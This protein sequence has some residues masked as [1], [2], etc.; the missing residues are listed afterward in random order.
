MT[1][2][3]HRRF[4][5]LLITVALVAAGLA[6]PGAAQAE[7][8]TA[9]LV[10]SLQSELGCPGDWQPDCAATLMAPGAGSTYGLT[11]TVPA[12]SYE[13]KV[14]INGS[15]DESYGSE[16]GGN[17]PLVIQGPAELAFGYDDVSHRISIAPTQLSGPATGADTALA[18]DS[19]R[20]GL[21][22]ERFYFLMADRFANGSGTN[23]TGGLT[24][25]RL[26][27]GFDPTDKGF[28]HGGDLRGVL[29]RLDYIKGLGTTAIWLTPS[30]KNRPVQGTGADASAGYHGYWITDFTQIDP[31]LGTNA[32]MRALIAAAHAK[33]M[34]VFFDIITNHTADVIDYA[35]HQ[36]TYVSKETTPYRDASGAPF[37][38]AAY[39][40]GDSFPPVDAATSFPYTPVFRS[41]A[42]AT[43]KVP[44]WLNDPT[45]YH[46][47]G[48]STFAGESSTY[49]DFVGLDDLWTERP[50]VVKGM[51]E[52]YKTWVDFGIDGF[53]IDTVKHVNL[54]FWQR[55]LPQ[56]QAEAARVSK[57][58]FFM[59]GEIYDGNPAYVSQFTTAGKLAAALDFP[60]QGAAA[61]FAAGKPTTG[62]RDV[63]AG[64]D[65][66][67]DADSNAYSSPT[68]L[69]NHDMGRLAMMLSKGGSSGTDLMARVKLAN[70]LMFLTRG[71]P[72]V[73]YGDEQGFIGAGGDKDARQDMFGTQVAQYAAET[74]VG[75]ATMGTASHFGTTGELYRSIQRLE[76]LRA[77]YPALADGAQVHRLASAS[78]GIFAVSRIDRSDQREYLV[79]LNNSSSSQSASLATFSPGHTFESIYGGAGS[80]VAGRDGRV[81]LTVPA[82][83]AVVLRADRPM[84]ARTSAP[85]VYVTSPSAG[86]IVGGRAEIGAA[87]PENAFA[88]VTFL[89]RPVGT[90]EWTTLGT[91]DNAPYRV[92]NDVSGLAHGTLLEYRVLAKDRSGNISAAASYGIVGDPQTGGGGGGGVGPVIQP[93]NVS[94]PGN[95][96]SEMGCAGDWD[97][98]C[99][100]A[101]LAL[102][103]KDLVWKGSYTIPA[104]DYEFKA[105]IDKSWD[106]NYGAGAVRNGGN[107]PYASQGQPV[108][109]YYDH[110]TH[111]VTNDAAGPIITAPGSMQSE[112]GCPADWSPDC[113]RPWLQDPDGDGTFTWST[114]SIPAGNYEFKVAHGLSWAENYGAGGA[115]DGANI[116]FSVPSDG[117]VVTFTYVLA[118]HQISVKTSKAGATPDLTKAKAFLVARDLVAWPAAA[119]PAGVQPELLHWRLHW[120][121]TGGLAVDEETVTGGSLADLWYDP[122]GLPSA[123]LAAHPE[124]AGYVALRVPPKTAQQMPAI[125]K[126]QLAV[127][128]YDVTGLLLDA[129]GVQSAIGLDS[130]FSRSA[131][132]RRYGVHFSDRKP[133]FRV[134]APTAQK[135]TLL[136]WPA[137]SDP[138]APSSAA[139]RRVMT[140]ADDGSWSVEGAPLLKNARYLYE[141]V[142]YAPSTGKVETNL[143]TDPASV[144]LTLDSTRSVAVD[145]ADAAFMPAQWRS[146]ASPALRSAVDSTIYELHV[147]DFSVNDTTIPAEHRGSYLAFAD[148]GVGMRH[149]KALARA[150][151]NTVHLLP[152]FDIAS[153]EED[154]AK[155]TTPDC[156]LASLAPQSPEQQQCVM[157]LASTDAFNWGY[158]PLHWSAPEGSYASTAA[159]AD[160]GARVAEFRTMVGGLH[161]AGLR[162]VLDEVFNHTPVS[163]QDPKS[164]LD[165]VVPGY[166]H[167]LN[168]SGAVYTS[169]CCQ[170]VATEH[171]MA[172]KMVVDSVLTWAKGY[173]VDGFRFDLMGHMSTANMA[174]IR[175]ALDGL[176]L[177]KDGVDGKSVYLYGEGWN[178][179]EVANNALFRQATQGQLGGTG[180]GAFSDRLRDAVRGGGPFDDNPRRQGFG[181]GLATNPNGDPVNGD[182]TA[183]SAALAH[184]T[185]LVQLG[186]AGNLRSFSFTSQASGSVV[187]GTEVD[188]NGSPA[189]YADQPAEV[190]T[191]VDAHDNETLFDALTFKLPQATSMA[192]RVRMNTVSLATTALAQT[193]MLWHAGADL[194]RSKSLDRNSYNSGDWFNR[195]DPTGVDNGFGH[196]LPP[197][198]D[199]AAK[200]PY[201]T[202]LLADPALKPTAADVATATAR[203]QDLLR[204]RFSTPLFRLGTADLIKAKV[205][206]PVSGT[207]DAHP[208]VIVMRIDDTVGPDVDPTLKGVVV[209]FNASPD[210]VDQVVPGL[211]GA[212]L[213]LSDVHQGSTDV[214][215]TS[216]WNS[217]T[218]TLSVPAR[219]VAVF[220]QR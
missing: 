133:T 135:V 217:T 191:Y 127:A 36:Y 203:A 20:T 100:Q 213:A 186:L 76:Q 134:W 160:G 159:A 104:G 54:Q 151:L 91:D 43:V 116:G 167:R 183:Q 202:P 79:V 215:A 181:S 174:A 218:A 56:I 19:L 163:G 82:L 166:Y 205:S 158:D 7:G 199:N 44:A 62:V 61:S 25:G 108:T 214:V 32:D 66:Y 211:T 38:D 206:F 60:F 117:V 55:F 3:R 157:A 169:T 48:D 128:M 175:T 97:P 193:P 197:Q 118:T 18:D 147:R 74:L 184:A 86:D 198:A 87:V 35:Q 155:Q 33:G 8:R 121:R 141:V 190:I 200:W 64:D 34:K 17:I 178:F 23:N 137:G 194:L 42:D 59:F 161:A 173:H 168:A 152:T 49:G 176:T 103:P 130:M 196:G 50:E 93:A 68:F 212:T 51:G 143:V 63:F 140:A 15:W 29:N 22:R 96:N 210:A 148:D 115:R 78:A 21:T 45:M 146:T 107:I 122:A 144:A 69:G 164:I 201:M 112:L 124:L 101:Q 5:V 9:T 120:S 95:L 11:V 83:S 10:G 2:P 136:T 220:V 16:S 150:G 77:T 13:L 39:A 28:Y 90:T 208:G 170:N 53:R 177:A 99:D 72:I 162:V 58:S 179:G 142:V 81:S 131:A 1:P 6:L 30:F 26:D 24:G 154:P 4:R 14:A 126:G 145:L 119:I 46:N 31:H 41:A 139:S 92:F 57:P 172:Q 187:L 149:L 67:I 189:G 73:Y 47:R 65:Y 216:S 80:R 102:D 40:A 89:V 110:G 171:A 207:A 195:F 192:D 109:F 125:L 98:G 153:I 209:V 165:R 75:G 204:L 138:A 182:A 106:E 129:T 156:D 123:L 113:M 37:D 114:A 94:V 71:N 219:T 84:P 132:Q 70:A 180:I 52:I 105:A 188:Y 12:G 27:T 185:D 85:A 88:Q 111:W